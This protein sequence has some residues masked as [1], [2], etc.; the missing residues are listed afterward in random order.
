M[1]PIHFDDRKILLYDESK[2]S[3]WRDERQGHAPMEQIDASGG[4]D[5][6]PVNFNYK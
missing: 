3:R 4:R 5:D 6:L 2:G 1:S